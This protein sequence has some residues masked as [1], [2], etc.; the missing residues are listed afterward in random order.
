[1]AA[2]VIFKGIR[3]S[4]DDMDMLLEVVVVPV[5]DIDKAKEYYADNLGFKVDMDV[6]MEDKRLVQLTPAGSS[7]SIHIGQNITDMT[8]GSVKGLILV[9]KDAAAAKKELDDKGVETGEI[10]EF[11][12]GKH[13]NL[14]DPDGNT[15]TIQESF[16]RNKK[17]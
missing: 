13:V 1:M 7:C 10:E 8:P 16:A 9:V 15:L 6:N 11:P 17:S 2:I 14:T 4:K 12:W 5:S 3:W